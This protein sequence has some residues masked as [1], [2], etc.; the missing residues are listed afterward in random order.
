[1]SQS[2]D[3]NRRPSCLAAADSASDTLTRAQH[4]LALC[5]SLVWLVNIIGCPSDLIISV[6]PLAT[7]SVENEGEGVGEEEARG[8]GEGGAQLHHGIET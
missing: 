8:R 1:M 4:A 6:L 7:S 5:R 3:I 2:S